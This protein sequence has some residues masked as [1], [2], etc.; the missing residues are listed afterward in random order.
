MREEEKLQE[1]EVGV[2]ALK[3]NPESKEGKRTNTLGDLVLILLKLLS[4][5]QQCL[6]I[7]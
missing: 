1:T 7:K 4:A 6:N 2:D 5:L 3:K